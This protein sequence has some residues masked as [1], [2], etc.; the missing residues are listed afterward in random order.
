MISN[1]QLF[2]IHQQEHYLVTD[3]LKC[4]NLRSKYTPF[5]L[6]VDLHESPTTFS[7]CN[8]ISHQ[9]WSNL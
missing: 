9:R 7:C 2:Y 5:S 6:S 1:N 8:I 4:H 3:E